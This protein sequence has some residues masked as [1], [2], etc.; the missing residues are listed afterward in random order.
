MAIE[1]WMWRPSNGIEDLYRRDNVREGDK[2]R[3]LTCYSRLI[4]DHK[5]DR[6]LPV[7]PAVSGLVT[8]R[9]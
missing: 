1:Q 9:V 3:D 6:G 8:V 4:F 7:E 5:K 2:G